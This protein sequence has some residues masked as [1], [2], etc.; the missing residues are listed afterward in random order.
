MTMLFLFDMIINIID[1][2]MYCPI[3]RL[4]V[5]LADVHAP[6]QLLIVTLK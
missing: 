3:L 6:Y 2:D 4:P 1:N 5:L